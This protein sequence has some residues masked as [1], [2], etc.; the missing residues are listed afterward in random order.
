MRQETQQQELEY[1]VRR[2]LT[3]VTVVVG[4]EV[5]HREGPTRDEDRFCFRREPGEDLS[6]DAGV[7]VLEHLSEMRRLRRRR[8]KRQGGGLDSLLEAGIVQ[9]R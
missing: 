8:I 9:R 1:L 4:A 3:T 7:E 2:Q 6:G 5:R